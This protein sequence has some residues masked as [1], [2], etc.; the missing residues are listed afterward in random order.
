MFIKGWWWKCALTAGL[1]IWAGMSLFPIKD[2]PFA[3][4]A[5]SK[6]TFDPSGFDA[7]I[8][9]AQQEVDA[10]QSPSVFVALKSMAL[11]RKI[12]LASYFPNIDLADVP[13]LEKRNDLLL[14]Y[15]LQSSYGRL[16]L[17]L[18]LEGGVAFT[19]KVDDRGMTE[20]SEALRA[21]QLNQAIEI[22][23]NRINGLGVVDPVIRAL[24]TSAI[25]VQLPGVSTQENPDVLASLQKPAK[26]TFHRVLRMQVP[27]GEHPEAIPGYTVMSE[28]SVN[29]KTGEEYTTRLYVKRIPEMGGEMVKDAFVSMNEYGAYQINLNFTQEG[30]ERF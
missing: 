21:E 30:A 14:N 27:T 10:G 22:L 15:L 1:L 26:L 24:G 4:Y 5:A 28:T 29:P 13:S 12:D 19:L 2:T 23:S 6:A 8:A 18:D 11:A 7:L 9:E 25:E 17:G 20:R 3:Q 16:K